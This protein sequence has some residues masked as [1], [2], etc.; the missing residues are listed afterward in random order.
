MDS[1]LGMHLQLETVHLR[2]KWP[3]Q[4]CLLQNKVVI[5]LPWYLFW[6]D[7][8]TGFCEKVKSL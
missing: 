7:D 8:A 6:S 4:N 1:I 5:F 3:S 2:L